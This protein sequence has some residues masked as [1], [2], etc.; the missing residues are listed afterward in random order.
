MK[1]REDKRPE[2]ATTGS[3]LARMY[4]NQE[5]IGTGEAA[6]MEDEEFS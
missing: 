1:V 6:G 3:E 4:E 5:A 2:Q